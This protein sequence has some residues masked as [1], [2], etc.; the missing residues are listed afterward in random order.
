MIDPVVLKHE[1][2]NAIEERQIG[3]YFRRQVHRR[4]AS[5][6]RQTRVDHDELRRVWPCEPVEDPRPQDWLC[7]RDV[8]PYDEETVRGV[9]VG[10]RGRLSIRTEGFAH[11]RRRR[12]RA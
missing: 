5:R 12:R 7:R 11:R 9:Y 1:M 2:L 6:I 3:A 4:L 8:V 10:I